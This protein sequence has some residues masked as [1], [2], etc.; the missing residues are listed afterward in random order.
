MLA[1]NDVLEH[2]IATQNF[3]MV[4]ISPNY[5]DLEL[6]RGDKKVLKT[7]RRLENEY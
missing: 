5:D 4:R 1:S 3:V 7:K 6:P 2:S